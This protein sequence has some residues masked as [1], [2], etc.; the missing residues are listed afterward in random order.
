MTPEEIKQGTGYTTNKA[1]EKYFQSEARDAVTVYQQ[2]NDL[3]HTYNQK[4]NQKANN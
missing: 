2:I 1:F 3:Q 4:N